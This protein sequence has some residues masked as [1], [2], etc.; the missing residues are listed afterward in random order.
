MLADI[1]QSFLG[2]PIEREFGLG[3]EID[4]LAVDDQLSRDI[5][6]A[7]LVYQR[8]HPFGERAVFG[9]RGAK[10]VSPSWVSN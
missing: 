4:R 10:P 7:A 5:R 1:G 9:R 2:S 8:R 6:R 3:R